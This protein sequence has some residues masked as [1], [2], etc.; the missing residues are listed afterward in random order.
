[1]VVGAVWYGPLFGAHWLRVIGATQLDLEARAAM[2]KKAGPLYAVQFFL[3]LGQLALYATIVDGF[4]LER[5]LEVS[6]WIWLGFIMPTIAGASMWNNDSA[7]VKWARFL[8]QSGYQ[9]A[10]FILFAVL[11][12]VWG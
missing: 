2:Q 7:S 10:I 8:I 4:T 9:L 6:F 12:G 3:V 1:M 11:F 5:T